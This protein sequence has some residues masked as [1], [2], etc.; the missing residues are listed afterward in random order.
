MKKHQVT[1]SNQPKAARTK[2][3]EEGALVIEAA[4]ALCFFVFAFVLL[5]SL[6]VYATAESKIQYAI[7]QTAKE[8]SQYCYVLERAGLYKDQDN[9]GLEPIDEG[10]DALNEFTSAVSDGYE[11]ASSL[12]Q[13]PA[14][15]GEY[16]AE[17]IQA[18]LDGVDT[19]EDD[20]ERIQ[21]ASAGLVEAGQT[22]VDDPKGIIMSLGKAALESA[23]SAVVSRVIAQPL[24]SSLTTKYIAASPG[25]ADALLT[26]WGVL[27][28]D[29]EP[30]GVAGL[31]FRMST[32]LQDRRT[33]NVVV[34]YRMKS[35]IPTF[36]PFERSFCQTAS[37]AGWARGVSLEDLPKGESPWTKPPMERGKYW[38]DELKGEY[39][40]AV[41]P[42]KGI[43]AYNQDSNT[44][45][46]Y[47][48]L[49]IFNAS[50]STYSG[51]NNGQYTL[52]VSA[53]KSKLKS[54]GKTTLTNVSKVGQSITMAD[55]TNVQTANNSVQQRKTTIV[56]V[57]P[58]NATSADK[59][60]LNQIATDLKNELGVTVEYTYRGK[61]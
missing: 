51:G 53:I 50:Y 42:G 21:S 20:F 40:N 4:F 14:I 15:Q 1:D 25:E 32:F 60:A 11:N 16:S 43:D 22:F 5:L 48:S 49:N 31:D 54:Y 12:S 44:F 2:Q 8:I 17:Q 41:E 18:I 3:G 33:I 47:H 28:A 10:I 52:N 36:F 37:T 61:A 30:G 58:D 34:V 29:G 27:G 35:L 55:G 7:N 24:C 13:N 38:V 59:A 6:A 39:G 23:G 57:I 46:S 45:Y 19:V 56:I 9:S 26:S